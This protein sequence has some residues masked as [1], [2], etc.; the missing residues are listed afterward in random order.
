PREGFELRGWNMHRCEDVADLLGARRIEL[1]PQWRQ[2]LIDLHRREPGIVHIEHD[3]LRAFH[4]TNAVLRDF[5]RNGGGDARVAEHDAAAAIGAL[6]A[7]E[8]GAFLLRLK[9]FARERDRACCRADK[10]AAGER[11]DRGPA[12]YCA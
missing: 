8:K 3:T 7:P 11:R 12:A 9:A 4:E 10:V 6:D 1:R 2:V 5:G